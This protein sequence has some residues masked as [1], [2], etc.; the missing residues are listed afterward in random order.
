M[1]TY[2]KYTLQLNSEKDARVIAYLRRQRNKNDCMRQALIER[3]DK[4]SIQE[5][6]NNA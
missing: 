5:T 3:M 6:M 1:A 2:E 4:E